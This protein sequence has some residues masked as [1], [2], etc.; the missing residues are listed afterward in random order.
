MLRVRGCR[1]LARARREQETN[2][3]PP[4]VRKAGRRGFHR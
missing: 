4:V 2:G 1:E 3:A